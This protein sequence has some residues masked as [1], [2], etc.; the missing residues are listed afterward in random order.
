MAS[1]P[2]QRK[3]PGG[4]PSSASSPSS[5]I[6]QL[7]IRIR[8]ARPGCRAAV[9]GLFPGIRVHDWTLIEEIGHVVTYRCECG[10]SK[11]RIAGSPRLDRGRD[12][13]LTRPAAPSWACRH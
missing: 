8:S 10:R 9:L 6:F 13:S 2:A 12:G 3:Q 7:G 1:W 11:T 4:S 5:A